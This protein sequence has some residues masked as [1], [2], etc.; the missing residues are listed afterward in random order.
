[1]YSYDNISHNSLVKPF[2]GIQPPNDHFVDADLAGETTTQH[3]LTIISSFM[4]TWN[5]SSVSPSGRVWRTQV[6]LGVNT[7]LCKP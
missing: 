2:N 6:C 5:Q 3:S 4:P 7:S 1:M